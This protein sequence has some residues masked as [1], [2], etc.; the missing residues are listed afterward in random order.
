MRHIYVQKWLK[1][2]FLERCK[3]N[4]VVKIIIRLKI[5]IKQAP[6]SRVL[7]EKLTV[8]AVHEIPH[9]L[10]N[11]KVHY[12]VHKSQSTSF[13]PICLRSILILSFYL[14]LYLPGGLH[15]SSLRSKFC[16]YSHLP[17]RS[18]C[19]PPHPPRFDHPNISE[20][21]QLWS[22]S[23]CSLL[24]PPATSSLSGPNFASTLFEGIWFSVNP[25]DT[26]TMHLFVLL[27]PFCIVTLCPRSIPHPV[28]CLLL[29]FPWWGSCRSS[30]ASR[31]HVGGS[32]TRD[33]PAAPSLAR[34]PHSS[35][36]KLVLA[37]HRGH[38]HRLSSVSHSLQGK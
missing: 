11:P 24:Y 17:I 4:A 3:V 28:W 5:N 32:E 27:I 19:P 12:R 15:P 8:S 20:E 35:P 29:F 23:S 21:Y 6:W 14:R 36:H 38:S 30:A 2:T 31:G 22:S 16:I 10:R 7:F 13:Q 26:Q 1:T 37:W 34:P 25:P 18:T 9:L 33:S